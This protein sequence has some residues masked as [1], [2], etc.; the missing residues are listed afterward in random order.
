MPPYHCQCRSDLDTVLQS[1][2]DTYNAKMEPIYQRLCAGPD[3]GGNKLSSSN[4][5]NSLSPVRVI[6]YI[7]EM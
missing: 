3:W 2:I 1:K 4:L 7:N 6:M 5:K